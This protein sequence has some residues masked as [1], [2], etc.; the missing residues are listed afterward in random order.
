MQPP[1][2]I[3]GAARPSSAVPA[4]G[5]AGADESYLMIAPHLARFIDLHQSRTGVP[6]SSQVTNRGKQFAARFLVRT[7][8]EHAWTVSPSWRNRETALL[9]RELK[10]NP[11][12]EIEIW[13]F[14]CDAGVQAR[15]Y[16]ESPKIHDD[17]GAHTKIRAVTILF[18]H[19]HF[20][21]WPNGI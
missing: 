15:S 1:D 18:H 2:C 5:R 3:I 9:K 7:S 13:G 10:S 11:K 6:S 19:E 4:H 12:A 20:G 17:A 21:S 8:R 16:V 14:F